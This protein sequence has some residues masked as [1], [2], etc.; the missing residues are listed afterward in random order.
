MAGSPYHHNGK[1]SPNKARKEAE[2]K[3]ATGTPEYRESIDEIGCG[4]WAVII[5]ICVVIFFLIA[6]FKGTDSAV[7]WIK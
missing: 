6:Y 3:Y 2:R 4:V 1:Y 5:L 7:N